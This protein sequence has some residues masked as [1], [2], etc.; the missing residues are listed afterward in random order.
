MR[1]GLVVAVG[2]WALAP[3]GA[4]AAADLAPVPFP[5]FPPQEAVER[6]WAVSAEMNFSFTSA[7]PYAAFGVGIERHFGSYLAL[8]ASVATGLSAAAETMTAEVRLDPW[9]DLATRVRF[10]LPVDRRGVNAFFLSVGPRFSEGGA[11]GT[12]WHGQIE[13]GYSLHTWGGFAL[14]YALGVQTPLV[15]RDP[16]IDPST[17]L[18]PGCAPT[19]QAGDWAANYRIG[20]GCSF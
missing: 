6:P 11:Y 13:L 9:L 17:C 14:L 5:R 19:A 2:V 3:T 10:Q 1:T 12:L 4:A 16:T 18:V 7:P 8:D 20:L 15:S